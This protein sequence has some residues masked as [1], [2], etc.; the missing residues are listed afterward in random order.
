MQI[1]VKTLTGKTLT[2]EVEPT[3]TVEYIK[4]KIQNKEGRIPLNQQRLIFSGKQLE[5]SRALSDYNIQKESTLHLV[6][7]FLGGMRVLANIPLMSR[8]A[9]SLDE[10]TLKLEKRLISENARSTDEICL[11]IVR[12]LENDHSYRDGVLELADNLDRV[13]I[14]SLMEHNII[15]KLLNSF[16]DNGKISTFY[17]EIIKPYVEND[18][19]WKKSS[20]GKLIQQ[21]L[22]ELDDALKYYR[23]HT[24]NSDHL[25][26]VL[27]SRFNIKFVS[28]DN[29]NQTIRSSVGPCERFRDISRRLARQ[30][31]RTTMSRD[32][33]SAR[34]RHIPTESL[35]PETSRRHIV[36][37]AIQQG[38]STLEELFADEPETFTNEP[39]N[40]KRRVHQSSSTSSDTQEIE[41]STSRNERG[42]A[43][44]TSRRHGIPPLVQHS[45]LE[46]LFEDEPDLFGDI[47]EYMMGRRSQQV[48]EGSANQGEASTSTRNTREDVVISDKNGTDGEGESEASFEIA[49][50]RLDNSTEATL[51]GRSNNDGSEEDLDDEQ[52][53]DGLE[54]SELDESESEV[55]YFDRAREPVGNQ[56]SNGS[57]SSLS[58]SQNSGEVEDELFDDDEQHDLFDPPNDD[59]NESYEE[60]DDEIDWHLEFYIDDLRVNFDSTLF[61]VIYRHLLR[62][63]VEQ[64]KE[65]FWNNDD[66]YIIKFKKV[67]SAFP[68][69]PDHYFPTRL[70]T[71]NDAY[72]EL[73]TR[74]MA[75]LHSIYADAVSVD[76]YDPS[77]FVSQELET[78]ID[79]V[80]NPVSILTRVFPDAFLKICSEVP[81][82]LNPMKRH[83]FFIGKTFGL[84]YPERFGIDINNARKVLNLIRQVLPGPMQATPSISMDN[85]FGWIRQYFEK[86]A[87]TGSRLSVQFEGVGGIGDGV[88]REFFSKLSLEFSQICRKM[89][90]HDV[91]YKKPYKPTDP[92][93]NDNGLYPAL[94]NDLFDE[95]TDGESKE[96]MESVDD[97]NEI[98]KKENLKSEEL[99]V[100]ESFKLLGQY[101]AKVI[102][103]DR[104]IILRLNRTFIDF[105]LHPEHLLRK[106]PSGTD[107]NEQ[108]CLKI[109]ELIESVYPS[110]GSNLKK[111]LNNNE[112]DEK[113]CI[114][115]DIM[116]G[117]T[118]SVVGSDGKKREQPYS[119]NH[120]NDSDEWVTR[121]NIGRYIAACRDWFFDRGIALQTKAFKEGFNRVF[122]IE[123]MRE[124]TATEFALYFLH[125]GGDGDWSIETLRQFVQSYDANTSNEEV[126][127]VI[128]IMADYD[129]D[130]RKR[131]L[132]FATGS[133][134]LPIGG[135]EALNLKVFRDSALD[136]RALPK[137]R[138]C[139]N[140][141]IIPPNNS[142]EEL[143]RKLEFA[144]AN[145][146]DIDRG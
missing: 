14:G 99:S 62:I 84:L 116:T 119:V 146:P 45:F 96:G 25:F 2:F 138:T 111:I 122:P 54:E 133:S 101:V 7:R 16:S 60:T 85:L 18:V 91:K 64:S 37:S 134:K 136:E 9:S 36:S 123:V 59:D 53:N 92:I 132:R 11:S 58:Q 51:G 83:E 48:G 28:M 107:L 3:D 43:S 30:I 104:M 17:D 87:V 76:K 127:K 41:G 12:K 15:D 94:M 4:Q 67:V 52:E 57:S 79:I 19:E 33:L 131:F 29:Q 118:T 93:D 115:Y 13:S 27:S 23:Y 106:L 46:E 130:S 40:K 114:P 63:D 42:E 102:Y 110:F 100:L 124:Y 50:R 128:Q 95:K 125:Q 71:G 32:H 6:L 35:E 66:E 39:S 34:R 108:D 82:V 1:F 86:Y 142:K 49:H 98:S 80:V 113:D 140:R 68:P 145:C 44:G 61:E 81:F 69:F 21:L 55:G 143:V 126:E 72:V 65:K 137:A 5:D 24:L 112:L 121:I 20:F 97:S 77:P 89:W 75:I 129:T 109:I 47:P 56:G 78:H 120:G 139:F 144:F 10:V 135:F 90:V 38:F 31:N 8:S 141:L 22:R 117:R 105:L 88:A 74:F 26:S 70:G 73:V 103:D